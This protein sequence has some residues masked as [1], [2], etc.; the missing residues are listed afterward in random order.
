M[1][2]PISAAPSR[3]DSS[4]GPVG[5]FAGPPGPAVLTAPAGPALGAGLDLPP[6]VVSTTAAI[7][8]MTASAAPPMMINR[9]L[10]PAGATASVETWVETWAAAVCCAAVDGVG[11]VDFSAGVGISGFAVAASVASIDAS[12]LSIS[13][14]VR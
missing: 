9:R 5:E 10:D 1:M 6:C 8:A 2:P 13:F 11:V 7:A 4:L 3:Y 14:R 12:T